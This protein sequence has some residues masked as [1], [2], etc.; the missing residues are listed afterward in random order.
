LDEIIGQ[1]VTN[2][3]PIEFKQLFHLRADD[4]KDVRKGVGLNWVR[5]RAY[6]IISSFEVFDE[7]WKSRFISFDPK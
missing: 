3:L 5:L 6:F 2:C 7:I 1:V 4:D